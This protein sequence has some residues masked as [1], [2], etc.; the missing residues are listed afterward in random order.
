MEDNGNGIKPEAID[1]I[2]EPFYQ[3]E[4]TDNYNN[5][6]TGLGLSLSKSLARKL[7][8][9]ISVQS[10]CGKGSTFILMLPVLKN[11]NELLPETDEDI[12]DSSLAESTDLIEQETEIC[13]LIVEDNTELRVFMKECLA[14]Q[15]Q[16]LEAENGVHAL[17]ILENNNVDIII[18]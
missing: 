9:D 16:I 7:G 4:T 11:E 6:G 1:K 13:I 17:K 2:F 8:G 14:E 5:K 15:Y 12:S 18:S 10:E 3:V